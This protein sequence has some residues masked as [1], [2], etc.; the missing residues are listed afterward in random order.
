MLIPTDVNDQ[1]TLAVPDPSYWA[2]TAAHYY[3]NPPG[4]STEDGCVWGTKE[5]PVGNWAPYV[6][7]ANQVAN[8]DTYVTIGWNPI[9]L[10]PET[11]FREVVPGYG[12][13][14]ECEGGGCN[15]LPCYIDPQV[16]GVNDISQGTTGAGG[17]NFCV[18]TVPQGETAN[19]VVFDRVTGG[20]K[21]SVDKVQ[22]D[23]T[24]KPEPS[25]KEEPVKKAPK[26]VKV[27]EVP[28]EKTTSTKKEKTTSSQAS[29]TSTTAKP[30]VKS[31]SKTTSS[32]EAS[33][34]EE[35]KGRPVEANLDAGDDFEDGSNFA[36]PTSRTKDDD[37]TSGAGRNAIGFT[38][39]I[40]T[41]VAIY[42]SL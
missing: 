2:S 26:E 31:S 11:P 32:E 34:T 24:T 4:V 13:R 42:A 8:G 18:V 37:K 30:R 39:F 19:V 27:E 10:E 21:K 41:V 17:A 40:G 1:S 7:G 12:I 9:Y 36:A 15:G 38:A 25:K 33:E 16:H 3:V 23:T 28:E 20:T 6:A 29:T 35:G 5:E 14:I 22:K